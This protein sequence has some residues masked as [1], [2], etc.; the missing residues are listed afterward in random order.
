MVAEPLRTR[1]V[2][3][4]HGATPAW[5]DDAVTVTGFGISVAALVLA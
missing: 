2:W 4:D 1:A 3:A 5:R